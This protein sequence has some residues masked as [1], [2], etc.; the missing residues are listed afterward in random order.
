MINTM[1]L[2][3]VAVES[4]QLLLLF[5]ITLANIRPGLSRAILPNIRR[6]DELK[7]THNTFLD[8]QV[9]S[10]FRQPLEITVDWTRVCKGT[11]H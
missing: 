8:C 4:N 1:F 9:H 5:F 3:T 2:T 6:N 11:G 7:T 10:L